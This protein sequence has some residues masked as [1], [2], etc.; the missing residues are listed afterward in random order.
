MPGSTHPSLV[1]PKLQTF[2]APQCSGPASGAGTVQCDL[3]SPALRPTVSSSFFSSRCP[4]AFCPL[5]TTCPTLPGFHTTCHFKRGPM[6]C[7]DLGIRGAGIQMASFSAF[8]LFFLSFFFWG[9]WKGGLFRVI[10]AVYGSS[11][12]RVELELQLPVYTTA[13]AT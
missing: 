12:A 10:L 3:Y 7:K 1:A 6:K 11:R 5:N 9:G 2:Q 13:T 8:F 4:V